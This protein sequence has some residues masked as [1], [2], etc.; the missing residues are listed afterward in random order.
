MPHWTDCS[1][2]ITITHSNRLDITVIDYETKIVKIIR[3]SWSTPFDA[4]IDKLWF[5]SKTLKHSPLASEIE[6]LGLVLDL[7]S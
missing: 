1:F 6:D 4:H 7:C 5:S 3:T 2:C